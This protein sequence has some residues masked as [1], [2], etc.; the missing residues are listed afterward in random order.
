MLIIGSSINYYSTKAAPADIDFS[1]ST[2]VANSNLACDS[3]TT[4]E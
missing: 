2:G 4:E 1:D 3:I